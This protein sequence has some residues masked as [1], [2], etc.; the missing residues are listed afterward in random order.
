MTSEASARAAIALSADPLWVATDGEVAL[1]TE[2]PTLPAGPAAL[3]RD[4]ILGGQ[5]GLVNVLGL[6]LGMAAATGDVR[7]VVT[8]GLAALLA[9]S[10]AMAGVAFTSS[11]AERQ[12]VRANAAGIQEERARLRARIGARRR[13]RL[14][15]RNLPADVRAAMDAEGEH[16]ADQWIARLDEEHA[17]LR[18]V[19][20]AR[21]I[22]AAVI[23]GISTAIGSAVPLLPFAFLPIASAPFVALACAGF[24]L[25]FA[26]FER[27]NLTG[28]SRRRA[29][30]EM[31]A[32]GIMSAFAGYLIGLVLRVP[33]A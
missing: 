4:V 28:G 13:S 8:A 27:A 15:E 24:V 2:A 25:A 3:V 20:E 21:P 22:R 10:I 23:V 17:R 30:A 19:R 9:E 12:L 7:V 16:D 31:L 26:G 18:P 5:D 29:A 14:A 1:L 33:A 6:V 32:I 11:G